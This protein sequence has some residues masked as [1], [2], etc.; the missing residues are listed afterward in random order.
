MSGEWIEVYDAVCSCVCS[1]D[2]QRALHPTAEPILLCARCVGLS[3]GAGIGAALG[4]WRRWTDPRGGASMTWGLLIV[5]G[6]AAVGLEHL[7]G[8]TVPPEFRAT[9]SA[10]AGFA[11]AR[12]VSPALCRSLNLDPRP[13]RWPDSATCALAVVGCG[14]AAPAAAALGR[15]ALTPIA[16]VCLPLLAVAAAIVVVRAV[17]RGRASLPATL[18]RAS[19]LAS[20]AF[21]IGYC[22]RH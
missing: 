4:V 6:L 12:F 10:L 22:L 17:S 14:V 11:A 5:A 18:A 2:S 1:Q 15:D 20:V 9:T 16:V 21:V 3:F 13:G 19:G 8:V 7:A